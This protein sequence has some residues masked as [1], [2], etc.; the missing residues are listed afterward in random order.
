MLPDGLIDILQDV[1]ALAALVGVICLVAVAVAVAVALA[2]GAF[3]I[4]L[5]ALWRAIHVRPAW[6]IYCRRTRH[7]DTCRSGSH[8]FHG[9][10]LWGLFCIAVAG[11]A[12]LVASQDDPAL[13]FSAFG[14]WT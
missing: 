3:F 10:W 1:L 6:C 14:L 8:A 4:Y 11:N 9:V 7:F 13:R 2:V 12:L 5:S